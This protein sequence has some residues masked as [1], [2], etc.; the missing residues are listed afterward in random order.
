MI[1]KLIWLFLLLFISC[2]YTTQMYLYRGKSIYIKPVVNNVNITREDRTYSS[3][4]PYPLLLD[5]DLT[6]AIITRFNIDGH[7]KVVS[8]EEADLRLET[9][10]NNYEKEA[11]RYTDTDEVS[12]QRLRLHVKIVLFDFQ[13]NIIKE[14]N[15]VGETSYFLSGSL[16]KSEANACLD[17][18]D[19]TARRI[20]EMVIEEW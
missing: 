6:N 4:S 17:L 19:D 15:I 2:G 20:I 12:E 3:Y 5:K 14:N 1:K 7:L 18:V 8:S 9:Y 16:A 10:I 11:L 13:N